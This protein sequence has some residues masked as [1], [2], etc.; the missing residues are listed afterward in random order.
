MWSQGKRKKLVLSCG[1]DTPRPPKPHGRWSLI[2][3][4]AQQLD[5]EPVKCQAPF[6]CSSSQVEMQTREGINVPPVLPGA[7]ADRVSLREVLKP[8]EVWGTETWGVTVGIAWPPQGCWGTESR[9]WISW[10]LQSQDRR[11]PSLSAMATSFCLFYL[12]A[13]IP[14]FLFSHLSCG[15]KIAASA[16]KSAWA[17]SS[18]ILHQTDHCVSQ[19]RFLK[20]RSWL[21]QNI[22]GL[23]LLLGQV[24][25]PGS[26]VTGSPHGRHMGCM[27]YRL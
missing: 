18:R 12:F 5:C 21:A 8:L 14:S 11:S 16:P 23:S 3:N 20:E 19:I 7:L 2:L 1:E 22:Y 9:C 26:S 15:P 27:A 13:T 4:A 10:G 24:T 25:T 17:S 6:H